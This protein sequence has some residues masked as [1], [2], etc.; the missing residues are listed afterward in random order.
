M[1]RD[2]I[3]LTNPSDESVVFDLSLGSCRLVQ[4]LHEG[5]TRVVKV[6]GGSGSGVCS[7]QLLRGFLVNSGEGV[8]IGR[9]P[10]PWVNMCQPHLDV[11]CVIHGWQLLRSVATL[12]V[13]PPAEGE[14]MDRPEHLNAMITVFCKARVGVV[15]DREWP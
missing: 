8:S 3:L 10:E 2:I 14:P 7:T 12:H 11:S 9:V 15:V 5:L 4:A 6:A 1:L 13:P